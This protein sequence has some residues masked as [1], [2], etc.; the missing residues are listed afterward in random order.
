MAMSIIYC[1]IMPS[2]YIIDIMKVSFYCKQYCFLQKFIFVFFFFSN[3]KQYLN[4]S[5]KYGWKQTKFFY[6]REFSLN[7]NAVLFFFLSE[8]QVFFLFLFSFTWSVFNK[9]F[10]ISF[11]WF[12]LFCWKK[13]WSSWMQWGIDKKIIKIENY[14]RLMEW[15]NFLLLLFSKWENLISAFY[16]NQYQFSKSKC[17]LS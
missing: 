3:P 13:Y 15:E 2:K 11:V 12:F 5:N 16:D 10:L 1:Y 14:R 6:Y 8:Y 17:Y 9:V 4:L 7:P